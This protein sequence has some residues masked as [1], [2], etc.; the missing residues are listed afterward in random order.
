[1]LRRT[2]SLTCPFVYLTYDVQRQ[3]L[4]LKFRSSLLKIYT[5]YSVDPA[6]AGQF[7][8]QKESQLLSHYNRN[9]RDT[10]AF[11]VVEVIP[12]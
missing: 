5:Y 7:L 10:F 8:V 4:E 2:T 11:K 9:V 1:M 3:E 6:S 12:A